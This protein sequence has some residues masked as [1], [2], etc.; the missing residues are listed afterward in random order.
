MEKPAYVMQSTALKIAINKVDTLI[1]MHTFIYMH[2]RIYTH[3]HTHTI[4]KH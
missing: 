1:Y 4:L 2:I 3:T